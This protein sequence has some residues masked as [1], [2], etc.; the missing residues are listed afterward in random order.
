[1]LEQVIVMRTFCFCFV[2]GTEMKWKQLKLKCVY[3]QLFEHSNCL[4]MFVTDIVS[5]LK[6][7]MY[8]FVLQED[9]IT[10]IFIL[11]PVN[12]QKFMHFKNQFIVKHHIS[13]AFR[14]YSAKC[15]AEHLRICNYILLSYLLFFG[16]N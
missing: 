7:L 1:M 13:T 8:I 2:F 15:F 11:S 3:F 6:E 10:D 12:V 16:A 4:L 14:V 5:F 9:I